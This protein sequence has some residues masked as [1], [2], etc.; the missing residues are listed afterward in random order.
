MPSQWRQGDGGHIQH[1]AFQPCALQLPQRRSPASSTSS[2]L[3]VDSQAGVH[4]RSPSSA[5]PHDSVASVASAR[6]RGRSSQ[7]SQADAGVPENAPTSAAHAQVHCQ[8]DS[9]WLYE[10]SSIQQ[11]PISNDIEGACQ[12]S[13]TPAHPAQP[14]CPDR[15]PL[16]PAH[17]RIP[18]PDDSTWLY[19]S[20]P[21]RQGPTGAD[22]CTLCQ[23]SL[24]LASPSQSSQH[25]WVTQSTLLS[26]SQCHR[27]AGMA[28]CMLA[29]SPAR[30]VPSSQSEV[31]WP[32]TPA[33]RASRGNF[34]ASSEGS[35]RS[36]D[37]GQLP[38]S[39]AAFK[40]ANKHRSSLLKVSPSP[41]RP[42]PSSAQ[43][44][45]LSVPQDDSSGSHGNL[46]CTQHSPGYMAPGGSLEGMATARRFP[47]DSRCRCS[48]TCSCPNLLPSEVSN[49]RQSMV[50]QGSDQPHRASGH[51]CMHMGQLDQV[52]H[53]LDHPAPASEAG[54]KPPPLHDSCEPC[55]TAGQLALGE[56]RHDWLLRP[57]GSSSA[58]QA[59]PGAAMGT[60]ENSIA[61]G[62]F[63]A[64]HECRLQPPPLLAPAIPAEQQAEAPAAC[65]P[66]AAACSPAAPAPG[67]HGTTRN[68]LQPS[69]IQGMPAEHEAQDDWPQDL[70]GSCPD[71][72]IT[73]ATAA[74]GVPACS[75]SQMPPARQSAGFRRLRDVTELMDFD[76]PHPDGLCQQQLGDSS[77]RPCA[78]G[79]VS[80]S[81]DSPA[82][83]QSTAET[84]AFTC[85]L[86]RSSSSGG[87]SHRLPTSSELNR[88]L[89]TLQ[90]LTRCRGI[91]ESACQQHS[92]S[93]RVS[94]RS[95]QPPGGVCE[96]H[97]PVCDS[98][99]AHQGIL[100]EDPSLPSRLVSG[101]SAM[102]HSR[103]DGIKPRF[104]MK[105]AATYSTQALRRSGRKHL[106]GTGQVSTHEPSLPADPGPTMQQMPAQ[107]D[108]GVSRAKSVMHSPVRHDGEPNASRKVP[109]GL[110]HQGCKLAAHRDLLGRRT[111][112]KGK[113]QVLRT[114]KGSSGPP[115]SDPFAQIRSLNHAAVSLKGREHSRHLDAKSSA[116]P[117]NASPAPST[118]SVDEPL[119]ISSGGFMDDHR[120]PARPLLDTP[121]YYQAGVVSLEAKSM[122]SAAAPH[123][124]KCSVSSMMSSRPAMKLSQVKATAKRRFS[125]VLSMFNCRMD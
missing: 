110:Q 71:I 117:S 72:Q 88:R 17:A 33:L 51:A 105:P 73:N 125:K 115:S 84:A 40:D 91:L 57:P 49:G 111:K 62:A 39:Q 1:E 69:S 118:L 79:R 76:S 78:P 68:L 19:H 70:L 42:G 116:L 123:L 121:T 122:Q 103:H 119:P 45:G 67:V 38:G 60:Y 82:D 34:Q 50:L 9:N 4:G 6:P 106:A 92:I 52:G 59:M 15:M 85:S 95:S 25:P 101:V 30:I 83:F 65:V 96:G 41:R 102:A 86:S 81:H 8:D 46:K 44:P 87:M 31:T 74:A 113:K 54:V 3:W 55:S 124:N 64:Q 5:R 58:G 20:S 56:A 2:S 47:A 36:A 29:M 13:P 75:P 23:P 99:K 35:P 90:T 100:A 94:N 93:D 27:A 77:A 107:H 80:L 10:T 11:G 61:L 98:S 48:V 114:G 120:S 108:H 7:N 104:A 43:Q 89:D 28:P 18:S 66:T 112:S 32:G 63:R 22:A 97:R 12:P 53:G 26:T 16:S 24:P 14:S 37:A 109:A 21:T